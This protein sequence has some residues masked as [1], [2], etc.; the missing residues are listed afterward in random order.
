MYSPLIVVKGAVYFVVLKGSVNSVNISSCCINVL[1]DET[2]VGSSKVLL[3]PYVY[4][5]EAGL[6]K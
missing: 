4:P 1:L 6:L 5:N 2:S 3:A